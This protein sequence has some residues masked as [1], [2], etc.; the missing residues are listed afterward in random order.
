[1]ID[2]RD[3]NDRDLSYLFYRDSLPKEWKI[4]FFHEENGTTVLD[5]L[6][7]NSDIAQESVEVSESICSQPTLM[8]GGCESNTIKFTLIGVVTSRGQKHSHL[9]RTF[10][11]DII[12][13]HD[14]DNPFRLGTYVVKI[15]KPTADRQS[16][17]ITAYDILYDTL[18]SDITD[19]WK[20]ITWGS[21]DV[22]SLRNLRTQFCEYFNIE[23]ESYEG[24]PVV[25]LNDSMR[26]KKF[27]Q[28]SLSGKKFLSN[29]CEV[30]GCFAVMGRDNKLHFRMLSEIIEGLYPNQPLYPIDE[31]NKGLFPVSD[32]Q[33]T[34]EHLYPK[35]EEVGAVV[36]KGQ[37]ISATYEDY[38]VNRITN[39]KVWDDKNAVI[40]S[41][42]S[43]SNI[44][45]IVDNMFAM[46]LVGTGEYTATKLAQNIYSK[47]NSIWYMIADINAIG[48]PCLEVG[49]SIRF[50]TKYDIVYIFIMERRM[51]GAQALKD[52]YK[53]NGEEFRLDDMA[54]RK[55][56]GSFQKEI[57]NSIN[58]TNTNLSNLNSIA[59]TDGNANTKIS[60]KGIFTTDNVNVEGAVNTALNGAVAG[61]GYIT[62]SSA[63]GKYQAKGNYLDQTTADGRYQAK[64]NYVSTLADLNNLTRNG[65]VY[66]N[67]FQAT[68]TITAGGTITGDKI[69]GTFIGSLRYS[70]G[71]T[72]S[73]GGLSFTLIQ[74]E[75]GQKWWVLGYKQ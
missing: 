33:S 74:N 73:V 12:L 10:T 56:S 45:N 65:V 55:P 25:L 23:Q 35:K 48:N 27:T 51:T 67:Q 52:N 13:N 26:V 22:L 38:N 34:Y 2:Y 41:Y 70:G 60:N 15:D 75:G 61:L 5:E 44:Y 43:G 14:V 47:V 39:I 9:N 3:Q 30:N 32:Q 8:F 1:M 7:T 59:W 64:G 16:R 49:D 62:E 68:T 69:D 72:I 57:T 50:V 24:Q 42:G 53:S 36:E 29:L 4:Q 17:E 20:S 66:A 18:N 63:D 19:W 31:N 28:E 71:N 6:Y 58:T 40:G 11:V 46:H 37:Y 21:G 54:S